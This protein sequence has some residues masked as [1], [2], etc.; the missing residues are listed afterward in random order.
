MNKRVIIIEGNDIDPGKLRVFCAEEYGIE[1]HFVDRG[2][3]MAPEPVETYC[4]PD[5]IARLSVAIEMAR[6]LSMF[7][8]NV[9]MYMRQVTDALDKRHPDLDVAIENAKSLE[10]LV[11]DVKERMQDV[12]RERD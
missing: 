12:S 5:A 3:D 9:A 1:V 6:V 2:D 4:D 7:K 10:R 8:H 11:K